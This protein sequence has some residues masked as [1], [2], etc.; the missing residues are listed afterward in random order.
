[1]C[2]G[3][4]R[5]HEPAANGEGLIPVACAVCD[6]WGTVGAPLPVTV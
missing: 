5:I 4:G 1:M 2:W 3:S 6:G